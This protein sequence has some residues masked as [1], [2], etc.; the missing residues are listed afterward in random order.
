MKCEAGGQATSRRFY[1]GKAEF[2]DNLRK[3]FLLRR[4]R[5]IELDE[6]IIIPNLIN[7]I[8]IIFV[9]RRGTAGDIHNNEEES[10]RCAP[11]V[12]IYIDPYLLLR[13]RCYLVSLLL[14]EDACA[15]ELLLM[16]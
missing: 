1:F 15:V 5:H 16:N 7:G 12:T 3:V 13:N 8:F 2:R 6:F 10:F 11:T 9:K 4:F 14:K